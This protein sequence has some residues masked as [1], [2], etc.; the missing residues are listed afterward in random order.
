MDSMRRV[1]TTL[2]A[3]A[4]ALASALTGASA[5]PGPG[6]FASG[7]V[8]YLST[9]PFDTDSSGGHVFGHYFFVTSSRYLDVYDISHPR[10][11]QRIATMPLP[12]TPQFA[13]EDL[14]TNGRIM[15]VSALQTFDVIDIR[16]RAN[17]HLIGTI[18]GL[19]PHTE[20]CVLDCS[21]AYGSEGQIVDLRRPSHPKLVGDWAKAAQKQAHIKFLNFHDV[22]EVRPGLVLTASQPVVLLDARRDPVHPRVLALGSTPDGRF[23]HDVVWPDEMRDP[24]FLVGGETVGNC[25]GTTDGSF[26]TW[27]A[28]NWRRTRTFH[29][30]DQFHEHTG[31]YLDGR[32][33]ADQ[34]CAHW[35]HP[36]PTYHAGG[37]VA[38]AWYDHGVRFFRVS[39]AGKIREIGYF[40]PAAAQSSNPY[41]ITKRL[42][43]VVDYNRGI[44]LLRYTGKL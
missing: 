39:H 36:N 27:S 44:D 21:Y 16:D 13:E 22:T 19:D 9:I 25:N 28:A 15:L 37:L 35:F 20:S 17:P 40:M 42:L 34:W 14:D 33:A 7:N 1:L 6:Y 32:P 23:I 18:D 2:C 30:I 38:M 24:F 3:A 8:R 11:P 31:N 5:S 10:D 26:M 43:Y 29:M 41:W 4:L 12:Q